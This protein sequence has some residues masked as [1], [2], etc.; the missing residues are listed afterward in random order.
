MTLGTSYVPD[1]LPVAVAPGQIAN[2]T[3]AQASTLFGAGNI[4]TPTAHFVISYRGQQI[5]GRKGV[6][7]VVDAGLLAALTAAGAP[8][9]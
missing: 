5:V 6:P 9:A 8:V 4:K 2:L 3:A 1:S 7:M